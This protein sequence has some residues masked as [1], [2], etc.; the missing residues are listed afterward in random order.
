[1]QKY[2]QEVKKIYYNSFYPNVSIFEMLEI[3][4]EL[5]GVFSGYATE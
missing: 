1:M 2:S 5:D 3:V 4:N